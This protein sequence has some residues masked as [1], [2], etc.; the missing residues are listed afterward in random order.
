MLISKFEKAKYAAKIYLI[1]Y[2]IVEIYINITFA[3][4]IIDK[5]TKNLNSKHFYAINQILS[6]LAGS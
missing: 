2:I 3:I 6:Y 5:F 1:M 4:S